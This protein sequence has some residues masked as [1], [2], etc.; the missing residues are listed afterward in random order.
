[1]YVR[2]Q[3]HAMEF[4]LEISTRKPMGNFY[5]EADGK[6]LQGSRWEHNVSECTTVTQILQLWLTTPPPHM[7]DSPSPQQSNSKTTVE[8]RLQFIGANYFLDM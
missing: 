8:C 1:M 7:H 2:I 4:C 3:V 6:F 5:K